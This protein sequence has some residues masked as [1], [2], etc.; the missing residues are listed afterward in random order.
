VGAPA[1]ARRFAIRRLEDA[2]SAYEIFQAT[3]G[4]PLHLRPVDQAAPG[5]LLGVPARDGRRGAERRPEQEAGLPDPVV[6]PRWATVGSTGAI[7]PSAHR[8]A[9]ASS[10]RSTSGNAAPNSRPARAWKEPGSPVVSWRW[11]AS[12]ARGSAGPDASRPL[13]P[14]SSAS[15]DA[16]AVAD[17]A[18]EHGCAGRPLAEIVDDT[19]LR[20][21]VQREVDAVNSRLASF[22]SIKYFRILPRD[23]SV[24]EGELT[25]S[26]KIKRRVVQ[27][28]FADRIEEMLRSDPPSR[29]R[30]RAT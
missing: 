4:D 9:T 26:L 1:G 24:E 13:I 12:V 27:K 17:W 30:E 25:P 8:A 28:K 29:E 21:A 19:G 23:F 5:G 15:A 3:D 22:E 20:A 11:V 6:A 2:G 7:G 10:T 14:S 16:V 18:K